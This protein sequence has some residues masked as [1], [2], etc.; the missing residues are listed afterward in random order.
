VVELHDASQACE[1]L[2]REILTHGQRNP[3]ATSVGGVLFHACV[4]VDVR[5]NAK[6]D[7]PALA[8]W[9]AERLR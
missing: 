9:A 8:R 6:I 5:H 1:G 4:P 2:A 3:A 7:R